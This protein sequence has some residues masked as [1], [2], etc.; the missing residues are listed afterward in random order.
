MV[1]VVRKIGDKT[2]GFLDQQASR[3]HVPNLEPGFPKSVKAAARYICQV[4]RS[5]S[6]TAH[7]ACLDQHVAK[8]IEPWIKVGQGAEREAGA[9]QGG[10]KLVCFTDPNASIVELGPPSAAG[11]KHF[12][13]QRVEDYTLLQDFVV[14][15]GYGDRKVRKAVQEIRGPV[16]RIDYPTVGVAGM[17]TAFFG[18]DGVVRISGVDH[19]DDLHFG[20]P[21]YFADKI[22]T[23]FAFHRYAL[24]AV[25]ISQNDVA[26]Q[27]GRFDGDVEYGM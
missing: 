10:P 18:D 26:G 15:E 6:G 22:V 24:K 5:R 12:I 7:A 3:S 11:G 25:Y 13:L 8:G 14:G 21:V 16:E 9:Y 27:S 20:E 1:L 17:L 2:P 23:A 19:P 4:Q